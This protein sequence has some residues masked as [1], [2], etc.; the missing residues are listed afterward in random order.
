MRPFVDAAAV[1]IINNT[2]ADINLM[3]LQRQPRRPQTTLLPHGHHGGSYNLRPAPLQPR[4][5]LAL[6]RFPSGAMRK[7][8]F[9]VG[10]FVGNQ[11][12]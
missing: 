2:I 3:F 1:N 11:R 8:F 7:A 5:S 4:S 6:N 10:G 9:D 12:R